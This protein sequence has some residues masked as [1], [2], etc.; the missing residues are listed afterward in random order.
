M[1]RTGADKHRNA[2]TCPGPGLSLTLRLQPG[3]GLRS[4]CRPAWSAWLGRRLTLAAAAPCLGHQP[5]APCRPSAHSEEQCVAVN[6]AHSGD[7]RRL[8]RHV[9]GQAGEMIGRLTDCA[10]SMRWRHPGAYLCSAV[11]PSHNSFT[12]SANSVGHTGRVAKTQATRGAVRWHMPGTGAA[13]VCT[14]P[15][16][17]KRSEMLQSTANLAFPV[18]SWC[19]L[20][21]PSLP[22]LA[23]CTLPHLRPP[24]CSSSHAPAA[25]APCPHGPEP[26]RSRGGSRPCL[27]PSWSSA[28]SA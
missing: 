22:A 12:Y 15:R 2:S 17:A 23:P 7:T 24:V 25:A 19:Q 5:R 11:D 13:K 1:S 26:G 8:K 10:S 20:A 21:G 4:P 14:T 28:W 18:A 16:L 3:A 9:G 27:P 6:E